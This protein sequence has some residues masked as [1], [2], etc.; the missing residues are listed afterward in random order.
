M[1]IEPPGRHNRKAKAANHAT[2]NSCG[3]HFGRAQVA[4]RSQRYPASS[5]ADGDRTHDLRLAKPALSQLSYD[6]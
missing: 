1:G 5:G 2:Q 4:T 6:P 3:W